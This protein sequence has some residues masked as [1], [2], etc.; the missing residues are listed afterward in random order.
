MKC[1]PLPSEPCLVCGFVESVCVNYTHL[2]NLTA[3]FRNEIVIR[4]MDVLR[5]RNQLFYSYE[6]MIEDEEYYRVAYVNLDKPHFPGVVEGRSLDGGETS[7]FNFGTLAIDQENEVVYLGGGR[8]IYKLEARNNNLLFYSSS[9]ERITS[10]VFRGNVF[11]TMY[12]QD[13]ILEKLE[14]SFPPVQSM[15]DI[16]VKNFMIDKTSAFVYLTTKGLFVSR[17]G[18]EQQLS[19]NPF[20]RGMAS[21]VTGKIYLWWIDTIYVA[22]VERDVKASRLLKIFHM[23]RVKGVTFDRDN[24]MIVALDKKFS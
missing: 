2:F 19:E 18:V 6:P 11:F 15:K 7:L 20:F 24:N 1:E 3:N 22:I 13:I 21:D 4:K 8:G 12:P 10:L 14:N 17:D 23:P 16:P 5:S 9:E